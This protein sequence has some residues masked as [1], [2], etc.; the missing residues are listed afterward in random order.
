MSIITLLISNPLM[1]LNYILAIGAFALSVN[2]FFKILSI[3][4]GITSADFSIRIDYILLLSLIMIFIVLIYGF[5]YWF[6]EF[7]GAEN[8]NVNDMPALAKDI[9]AFSI[10]LF[11]QMTLISFFLIVWFLLKAFSSSKM[12]DIK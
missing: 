11:F 7:Y 3:K 10:N 2:C 8:V 9:L 12:E 5:F 6:S 1:I 4:K